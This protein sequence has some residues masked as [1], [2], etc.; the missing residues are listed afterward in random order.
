MN[1]EV[2]HQIPTN[3]EQPI[4][5]T[6]EAAAIAAA[7]AA[8]PATAEQYEE[9]L[10]Y[11]QKLLQILQGKLNDANGVNIQLEAK[12]ELANEKNKEG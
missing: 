5:E 2:K 6:E 7:G 8:T 1:E 11:A 9:Q 4:T 10:K 3:A 12:L